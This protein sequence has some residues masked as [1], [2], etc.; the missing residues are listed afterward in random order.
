M[1]T[2]ATPRPPTP[3]APAIWLTA[4]ISA[5][6]APT[7]SVIVGPSS[8]KKRFSRSNRDFSEERE[9]LRRVP[10]PEDKRAKRRARSARDVVE[11]ADRLDAADSGDNR[12]P[13]GKDPAEWEDRLPDEPLDPGDDREARPLAEEN[14]PDLPHDRDADDRTES[15]APDLDEIERKRNGGDD[16]D[17]DRDRD[18]ERERGRSR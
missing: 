16:R 12:V 17:P 5:T 8:A 10:G 7:A 13:A 1:T 14:L 3:T 9:E 2:T 6:A 15:V 4:V 18:R 11:R